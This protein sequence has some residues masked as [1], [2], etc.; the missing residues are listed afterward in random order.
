MLPPAEKMPR[1]RAF[2]QYRRARRRQGVGLE[3]IGRPR[4]NLLTKKMRR[5]GG[6]EVTLFQQPDDLA[7]SSRQH[8][9]QLFYY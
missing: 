6:P 7:P 4:A 1:R 8:K 5:V 2:D 9:G 3:Y